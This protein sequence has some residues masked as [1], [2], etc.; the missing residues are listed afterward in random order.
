[1]RLHL[2]S[3]AAAMAYKCW[4]IGMHLLERKPTLQQ[5]LF[6]HHFTITIKPLNLLCR[7]YQ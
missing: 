4:S 6:T 3:F 5:M 7:D 2:L 1:M